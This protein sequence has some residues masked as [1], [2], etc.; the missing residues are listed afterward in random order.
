MFVSIFCFLAWME[1]VF[2]Y[3]FLNLFIKVQPRHSKMYKTI[4]EYLHIC[5]YIFM[6]PPHISR[7]KTILLPH[8][9]YLC[10]FTVNLPLPGNY[11]Y[12]FYH[13]QL[14]LPVFE[15]HING[16]IQYISLCLASF[17]HH[18]VCKIVILLPVS[19]LVF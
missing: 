13:Y 11:Y 1:W 8:E 19:S 3:L 16:I 5:I 12:N 4:D 2:D 18:Y 9:I 10:P 6:Y 14:T 7:Y 15:I 17:T